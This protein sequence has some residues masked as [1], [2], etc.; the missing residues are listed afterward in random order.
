[1]AAKKRLG[2]LLI[3][4]G[5]IDETML[6]SA[7]GH[8]RRWGGK[9]G[10]AILDLK[11]ASEAAI[12]EALGRKLG[13]EVARLGSL[14]P[15][16]L[17]SAL[18]L[19]G[20]DFSVRHT[21]FPMAADQSSLTVAMADPTN[22][23]ISDELRFRTNRRVKVCIGGDREIAEA[24]RTHYPSD[25]QQLE[26]ISLDTEVSGEFLPPLADPFGGGSTEVLE[27]Q[28]QRAPR[29]AATRAPPPPEAARDARAELLGAVPPGGFT[30]RDHVGAVELT[31]LPLPS[32]R[33]ARP[34][35]VPTP[36]PPRAPPAPP[37]TPAAGSHGTTAAPAAPR[38]D[39]PPR[40]PAHQPPVPEVILEEEL[41]EGRLALRPLTPKEIVVLDALER[42]AAGQDDVPLPVKPSQV[43]AAL[44]RIMLRQKIV[45]QQELLDELLRRSGGPT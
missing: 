20:K 6:H 44:L 34:A 37:A 4:A 10:Q 21:L 7:L 30:P 33:L 19:V 40:P 22:L 13:F 5:V 27:K 11:L 3:E 25:S 12:V 45:T 9:L 16:A 29:P 32:A 43:A 38:S 24:I 36:G 14:E 35:P 31:P 15:L 23:G 2:E 41:V 42:L 17:E 8:Q 26:A 28:M 18:R 1:M 39:A